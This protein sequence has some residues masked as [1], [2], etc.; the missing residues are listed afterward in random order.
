MKKLLALC[1]TVML[2]V[3]MVPAFAVS[4]DAAPT[5]T[6][7]SAE[8]YAGDEI[9]VDVSLANNPGFVSMKLLVAYDA[10]VLELTNKAA[11]ATFGTM[12]FSQTMD[13]NPYILNWVDA[14]NPDNMTNGAFATL[15]FKIKDGAAIG[16]SAITVTYDQAD[17]YQLDWDEVTFEVVNG[18]VNVKC[19][20][21]ETKVTKEA[22]AATCTVA[23]STAEVSCAVCGEVMTASEAVAALGHNEELVGA[24][25]HT[26]DEDGYTGDVVCTVCEEVI[27]AGEVILAGH[28]WEAVEEVAATC[29]EDGVKAHYACSLCDAIAADEEGTEVAA[30]DLVI[31][32][33]GHKYVDG[34]CEV[35]GEEEAKEDKEEVKNESKP[36][37]DGSTTNTDNSTKAPATNDVANIVVVASMLVAIAAAAV[38]VLK[39]K[40]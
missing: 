4:A 7:S 12:A 25:A 37:T 40:A 18:S 5:I 28:E 31:E 34:K 23:G 39:K 1:L 2:V 10:E 29:T 15:T 17:I 32:A 22:V 3:A 27:T 20:H 33:A 36:T 24:V 19:A 21:G 30:E 35:C 16:E 14:I 8:G 9:T 38:V 13:A 11:G 26:A 6:V